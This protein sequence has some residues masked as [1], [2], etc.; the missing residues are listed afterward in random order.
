MDH[1]YDVC[2]EFDRFYEGKFSILEFGV[3]DGYS[4]TKKLYATR[5]LGMED[6]VVV[7]GFDTFEG[8]PE[9]G[10]RADRA[11]VQGEEWIPGHYH[12]RHQDLVSYCESRY[13]N[14][15]LHKGLFEDVLTDRLLAEFEEHLPILIWSDCDYYS[16]TRQV[17]EKLIP[18]IPTGCVVYFD[19][20][21]HNFGSRFTGEMRAV[22]E[23]N[24][25]AFGDGVE[26][27]PEAELSCDYQ[28]RLPV[29]QPRCQG[30]AP[31]TSAVVRRPGAPPPQ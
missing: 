26:L 9:N 1:I 13:S 5:Y 2:R 4:F 12:G 25:G 15:R 10:D 22:S 16:S 11:L 18:Y 31:I 30:A 20:I 14:F 28:P 27:V 8:L 24:R 29:R 21:T 7:H 3:A 17:F 6:R 23:I 19:D